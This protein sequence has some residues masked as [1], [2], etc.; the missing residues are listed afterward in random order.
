MIKI[1]ALREFF[2]LIHEEK[3]TYSDFMFEHRNPSK[4]NSETNFATN[5]PFSFVSC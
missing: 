1:F 3:Y 2:S 5:T 4:S